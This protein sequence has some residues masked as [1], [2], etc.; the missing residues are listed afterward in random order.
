MAENKRIGGTEELDPR[1]PKRAS[2][3]GRSGGESGGGNEKRN[4]MARIHLHHI[5]CRNWT[6]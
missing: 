4:T 5:T 3:T 1:E 2:L 6:A